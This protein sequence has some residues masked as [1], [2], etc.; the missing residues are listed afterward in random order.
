MFACA[1]CRGKKGNTKC[2]QCQGTGK[3]VPGDVL[4]ANEAP[5]LGLQL[6]QVGASQQQVPAWH[7]ALGTFPG[8]KQ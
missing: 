8:F 2:S 3:V 4:N 5:E 7:P 6:V 1:K